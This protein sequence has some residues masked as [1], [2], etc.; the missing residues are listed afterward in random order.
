MIYTIS[1]FLAS[2]SHQVKLVAGLGGQAR[3]V[4][5]VAILDY[6]L[7]A[8]LKE[9]YRRNN[10]YENQLV[11]STF[12]YAKDD[13]YL[14]VEAVKY[15]VAKGTSGLVIKNVLH[16]SIPE[17]ALR[18][19]EARN[20]PIMIT[21]S[22]EAYFDV[23]VRDV[24]ARIV[25]LSSVDFCQRQLDAIW[26]ASD[27]SSKVESLARE[28]CPSFRRECIVAIAHLEDSVP[29]NLVGQIQ[30][31]W[32]RGPYGSPYSL[33]T[34]Y[35]GALLAIVSGD[36]DEI[37]L[38]EPA[39]LA[40][41]VAEEL[42]PE[43][44][45][46]QTGVSDVH[47]CLGEL[48]VALHQAAE[49]AAVAQKRG[50]KKECYGD[51][52]IF[53]VVLPFANSPQMKAFS[54]AVLAPLR[55]FDAEN[56][57]ALEATLLAWQRARQSVDEAAELLG[58]HPNTVRYRFE[59]IRQLTGLDRRVAEDAQQLALAA[60]IAEAQAIIQELDVF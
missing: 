30:S 32:R 28:I 27:D 14:I 47:F 12:L 9:K 35:S 34:I 48:G 15:L 46:L 22:D 21:T 52:G 7:M 38:P 55:E 18:Y 43:F 53:R 60:A 4:T 44:E 45:V 42:I 58:Q 24:N 5:E 36:G 54:G 6:E 33:A 57:S 26:L 23:I 56:R 51:L 31:A 8:G 20:Y 37:H 25:D 40:E 50:N 19:A 59:Q 49:A 41:Y 17:A 10:F 39:S 29:P 13:P 1:D 3:P 2:H 11:L 16:L